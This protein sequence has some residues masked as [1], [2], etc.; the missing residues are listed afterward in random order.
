MTYYRNLKR[1]L[2]GGEENQLDA[3]VADATGNPL[4][5]IGSPPAHE[6]PRIWLEHCDE[7]TARALD[8]ALARMSLINSQEYQ[9]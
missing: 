2:T 8:K 1:H 6:S 5:G 4:A 7:T 3:I 9:Q